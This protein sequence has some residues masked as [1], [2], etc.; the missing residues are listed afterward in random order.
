MTSFFNKLI[1]WCLH[2]YQHWVS[3]NS[4]PF[5]KFFSAQ[6][7]KSNMLSL[8]WNYYW[9]NSN[10]LPNFLEYLI[11]GIL[12][13]MVVIVLWA[14][15]V[16]WWV[17]G[18]NILYANTL[19]VVGTTIMV[20]LGQYPTL[21]YRLMTNAPSEIVDL[22]FGQILWDALLCYVFSYSDT[23]V[24]LLTLFGITFYFAY[25][26]VNKALSYSS[27]DNA[28]DKGLAYIVLALAVL[29]IALV[30]S[31]IIMLILD[32]IKQGWPNAV[33]TRVLNLLN[34]LLHP[35]AANTEQQRKQHNDRI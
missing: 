16:A 29:C 3:T 24:A 30:I 27:S 20:L 18:P 9:K 1:N 7:R 15:F 33:L 5:F 14:Y 4:N 8:A 22:G 34:W 21:V 35:A 19:V 25:A 2:Q 31:Y 32:I 13:Y 23:M 10:R 6:N 12:V 26:L 17:F 28:W 11:K